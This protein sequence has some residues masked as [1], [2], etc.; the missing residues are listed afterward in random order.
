MTDARLD[1]WRVKLPDGT[2][3]VRVCSQA[4]LAVEPDR[5]TMPDVPR[6]GEWEAEATPKTPGV[7]RQHQELA[8]FL[9]TRIDCTLE[10]V[11][12]ELG[13][14]QA[15]LRQRIADWHGA[16][17]VVIVGEMRPASRG[18]RI[19]AVIKEAP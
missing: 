8:A 12:A 3:V 16:G 11:A 6:G 9:R 5:W 1:R 7:P 2:V 15:T 4:L 19:K 14:K 17:G 18:P 10:S 13:I